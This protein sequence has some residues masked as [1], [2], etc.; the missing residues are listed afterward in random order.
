[1]LGGLVP[2]PADDSSRLMSRGRDHLDL[3]GGTLWDLAGNLSEYARDGFEPQTGPCWTHAT[4]NVFVDPVCPQ[5]TNNPNLPVTLRGGSW[6]SSS[7]DL[8]AAS[9]FAAN[10]NNGSGGLYGFIDVGLRCVWPAADQ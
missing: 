2:L 8:P 9:R 5:Q 4:S 7:G 10:T 1:M 3:P 6:M